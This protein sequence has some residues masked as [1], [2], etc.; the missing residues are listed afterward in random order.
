M[1]AAKDIIGP[2]E[3]IQ[4]GFDPS[5]HVHLDVIVLL[6]ARKGKDTTL[7]I[8]LIIYLHRSDSEFRRIQEKALLC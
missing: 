5:R 2:S 6:E 3:P 4:H 8:A 7:N 1:E